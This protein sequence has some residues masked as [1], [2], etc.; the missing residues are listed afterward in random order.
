M[1]YYYFKLSQ[2][3]ATSDEINID[4]WAKT[5]YTEISELVFNVLNK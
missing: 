4:K 1:K 5:A 2:V 3:A